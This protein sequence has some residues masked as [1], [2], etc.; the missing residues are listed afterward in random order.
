MSYWGDLK[1]DDEGMAPAA[2]APQPR[3]EK[4][5]VRALRDELQEIRRTLGPYTALQ[6]SNEPHRL[7]DAQIARAVAR[8]IAVVDRV[9]DI[10][11]Q[12]RKGSS[13]S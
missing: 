1:D 4:T 12:D 5:T 10:V 7:N 6:G 11:D 3:R 2:A 13:R 8:L 9:C